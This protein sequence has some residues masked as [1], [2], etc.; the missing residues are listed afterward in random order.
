MTG[1]R[2]DGQGRQVAD[3]QFI[4]DEFLLV[5]RESLAAIAFP[6]E[7]CRRALFPQ[8]QLLVARIPGDCLEGLV[9]VFRRAEVVFREVG[10]VQLAGVGIDL[11]DG[12]QVLAL[13]DN[14]QQTVAHRGHPFRIAPAHQ[15]HFA[16]DIP[17]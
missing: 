2:V 17:L 11:D 15:G 1:A 5:A 14:G 7:Q 4:T 13:I 12:E 8:Q 3:V 16:Q 6:A 10:D 9:L